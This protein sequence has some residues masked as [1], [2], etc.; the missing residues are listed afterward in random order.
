MEASGG[1]REGFGNLS[2]GSA[3]YPEHG[4]SSAASLRV[5]VLQCDLG[6]PYT[7]STKKS[8]GADLGF[9]DVRAQSHSQFC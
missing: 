7:A 2:V 9:I 3:I 6:L 1:L 4:L 5:G 8:C